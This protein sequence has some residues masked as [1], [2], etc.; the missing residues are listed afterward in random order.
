MKNFML[1]LFISQ[2]VPMILMG[3]EMGRTQ[4]GNNNAYCQDNLTTWVDWDL[5][6]K[7]KNYMNLLKKWHRVVDASCRKFKTK[8]MIKLR[9]NIQFFKVLVI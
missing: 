6:E 3:D 4:R 5:L 2:G 1:I 8:N 9:K 7:I